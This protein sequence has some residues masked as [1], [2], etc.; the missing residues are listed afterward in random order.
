MSIFKKSVHKPITTLMI[1]T[2]V[3]VMGIYS[4]IFIPIDLYPEM[5]PP[6]ISVLTTY[7]GANSSD[8]ESNVTRPLEDAFN[9][10]DNLKEITS[11]SSDNLSVINLEF[12]WGADLN[13]ASND[14]RDAIDLI[15]NNLPDGV[16]RP[17]IFKFNMSMFPIVFYAITAEESYPGL[18]K[19]LDEKIIN[20]L[21]RI[22][23]IGSVSLIG[24]P[25]RRIYI[26]ADPLKL[27][28][29]NLTIE[30]LG[31]VIQAENMNLPTGNIKMGMMDYQLR[32]EGEMQESYEF[33]NLVVGHFQ[34]KTIF[35]KDVAKVRDGLKDMTLDERINMRKGVRMFVMKQS[36][37]NTVKIA[38]E[39]RNS[40]SR[41]S[42][43]LPPDITINE[44]IDTSVFISDSIKNLSQTM[45]WAL[46]FVVIVVLFFLGRWRATFIVM[47][48]IPIS[49]IVS[50]IYLYIT[51][52]SLNI[53]S[54]ASLSIALGMVVDDAIVVLENITRHIERGTSP[55]EAAIYATNEVWLSVIITTL[56]V[57]AVFFPLTLVG[58]MTG[59]MFKQLGWIVT[60][61]VVTSTLAAIT[62]TP[63][64]S[65]KLLG[66][67]NKK[68]KERRFSHDRI[69][70]PVLKRME[71]FYEKIIQLALLNKRK[72]LILALLFF[73]GSL[74]LIKFLSVDFMPEPDESRMLAEIELTTGL[75][76][77]ETTK[78]SRYLE[79][80]VH[81]RFPEVEIMAISSGAEEEGG[82]FALFMRRGSNMINMMTRLK[83]IDER[84]RSVWEVADALRKELEQIPEVVEF[85]VSTSGGSF[86]EN[87]V[88]IEIFG[89][90]FN[91]TT[92][93]A[94]ELKI[95]VS[96]I[97]GAQDVQISRK[98]DRPE[99]QLILDR[100][101][102]AE[103]GLN[104]A[105]VATAM[106]NRV[107]GMTASYLREQ[108][109]E[110][111][112]V[113]RYDE[114]FRSS[115][116]DLESFTIINPMGSK[117]KLGEIGEI[118]EYWNPPNIERKRRERVVTVSSVPSGISLGDLANEINRV[119]ANTEIPLGVMVNVGGAYED[120]VDSFMDL[121]L[122]LLISIILVFLVMASQFESFVMPFVIMFSI[123]FSFTGVI[124][125]LLIT[126][127]TLSLIAGLGAVLLIGIVVKNGIVLV[128]YINLMRDRE[129]PLN[130]AIA[131]AGKM[132][133]RP[134]L[135][136]AMTTILAML[137]LALSTG[138]GS[139]IWSPMG[140]TLIGGLVFSTLVTLILV[141]VIYG[142][143]SRKG[144][145]DKLRL[146]R[147]K[148]TFLNGNEQEA[149]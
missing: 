87:T 43:D 134:V 83:S 54:L 72:I 125:A 78:V 41:L 127:T 19:I 142:I 51:G 109:D 80:V 36:G 2:A 20:P 17:T 110:Y 39:V 34:G 49:L 143:V 131:Y 6:F 53:I 52:G 133:L 15:F 116:S 107:T 18:E 97:P 30:Q 64:L 5:D 24:A 140:I 129:M 66:L 75:R 120:M 48:T 139:E 85:N 9:T 99:L 126:N 74:F 45:M 22:E 138:E 61:T 128:D 37:A 55:R 94:E 103:N 102:L 68:K 96:A 132:R 121:G 58:G 104:T 65:S 40:I 92:L 13:E 95:A 50:F 7:P 98:D 118:K 77:E 21:N 149:G 59:V 73:V 84:D 42:K 14:I 148:Y 124:L 11:V 88:D 76:V 147:E 89:Y 44:I 12:D 101:K 1:F 57:V 136:T 113:V 67:N 119:I 31:Q 62:L 117:I 60:I 123:P 4:I 63:M 56:V 38:K 112:I 145:R 3:I 32:V 35:L 114:N 130:Q 16:N 93:L 28:A 23:G 106:R 82:M 8:I 91:T 79:Q 115:V 26:E 25:Q 81:D 70:D 10:I 135:M 27:E 141:P 146:I 122:L 108:G 100:N 46:F 90:D 86:G 47:L 137:P 33:N 111:D 105:M 69:I 144:E 71:G 29:Y